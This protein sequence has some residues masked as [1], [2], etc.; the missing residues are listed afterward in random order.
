MVQCIEYNMIWFVIVIVCC[1]LFHGIELRISSKGD[2]VQS[3][4]APLV[5]AA[6]FD[7]LRAWAVGLDG[8]K[9]QKDT[10]SAFDSVCV[11]SRVFLLNFC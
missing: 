11:V 4:P 9:F 5:K 7:K 3:L 1:L 2:L 6:I 10:D 8:P